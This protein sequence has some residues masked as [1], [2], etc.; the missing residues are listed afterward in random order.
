MP[1]ERIF[2]YREIQSISFKFWTQVTDFIIYDDN[3]YAKRAY[4][5]GWGEGEEEEEEEEEEVKE[6]E[7]EEEQEEEDKNIKRNWGE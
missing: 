4:I 6:E 5:T 2:V 1:F 3:C 7:E